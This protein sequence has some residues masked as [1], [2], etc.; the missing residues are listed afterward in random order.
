MNK[1]ES[2]PYLVSPK[3]LADVI[4]AIQ[5]L[6]IYKFNKLTVEKWAERIGSD[7]V[8]APDWRTVFKEHPE[9]FRM[10]STEKKVSLVWRRAY[11][12]RFDV[13]TQEIVDRAE[14]RL[15]DKQAKSRVTRAPLEDEQIA[16]LVRT[17]IDL[18]DRAIAQKNES[19]WWIPIVVGFVGIVLGA[20]LTALFG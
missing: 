1:S 4:A 14:Y 18:H 10:G 11:Q 3:R 5:F 7:P 13:D 12:K 16:T 20:A 17:A 19:R 2:S 9:F 15:R 6:G 8:S